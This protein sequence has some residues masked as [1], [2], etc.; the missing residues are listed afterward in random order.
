MD[1]LLKRMNQVA[2]VVQDVHKAAGIFADGFGLEL[3][4]V[5]FGHVD[6]DPDFAENTIDIAQASLDGDPIGTYGIEMAACDMSGG[7][8]IELIQPAANRSLFREFLDRCG[9]GMQ[10][11]AV[12]SSRGF[13]ETIDYMAAAGNPL[14]QFARVDG[15]QEECAFVRHGTSLGLD[16]EL[17]N[18]LADFRLPQ[19]R[20]NFIKPD[21][22]GG[23]RP[24]L[25]AVSGINIVTGRMED[26]V[27]L[28]RD[29]YGLT[30]WEFEE[31][32][33]LKHAYCRGLN[34]EIQILEPMDDSSAAA[35]WRKRHGRT[36]VCSVEFDCAASGKVLEDALRRMGRVP[37][38]MFANKIGADF[39]DILGVGLVFRVNS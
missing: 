39:E 9:C 5:R 13:H 22:T 31:A 12:E 29:R 34:V 33:M 19:V 17:H 15:D 3:L 27:T 36:G 14:G 21:S 4:N 16:M 7:V 28:L 2:F 37:N 10:H 11:I 1:A 25:T 6:G 24:A 38:K 23:A 26:A 30:D 20:P 35:Q 18:R 8:Q 32:H